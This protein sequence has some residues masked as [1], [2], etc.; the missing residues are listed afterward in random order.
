MNQYRVTA[1]GTEDMKFIKTTLLGLKKVIKF[2]YFTPETIKYHS[3]GTFGYVLFE[4][5]FKEDF[6]TDLMDCF[7]SKYSKVER[8]RPLGPQ[9]EEECC[10]NMINHI[11][12]ECKSL[13]SWLIIGQNPLEQEL[14]Q[15]RIAR[16]RF[17]RKYDQYMEPSNTYS[18]P[19]HAYSTEDLCTH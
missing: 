2:A 14:V 12:K 7:E 17:K 16:N 5:T 4:E 1:K 10:R 3:K 18:R 13:E 19:T 8:L 15:T 6:E 11:T 9:T